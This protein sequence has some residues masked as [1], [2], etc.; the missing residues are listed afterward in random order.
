MERE[1]QTD[2][3]T[4]NQREKKSERRRKNR[5]IGERYREKIE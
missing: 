1:E 3:K 4:H 2:R 5:K